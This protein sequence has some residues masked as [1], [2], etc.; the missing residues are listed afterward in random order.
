MAKPT[1]RDIVFRTLSRW[2][3][4]EDPPF[5]PERHHP[6]WAILSPRDR[7]FAYDLL[8]GILRW[9]G[10]LETVI[11][12][13]LNQRFE[14]LEMGLRVALWMGAYQLLFQGTADYAA[15]N[16]AVDLARKI[17]PRAA[18]LVNAVLRAITRLEPRRVAV[19]PSSDAAAP[20]TSRLGRHLIALDFETDL[21]LNTAIFSDPAKDLVG[22]L[23]GVRSHPA[24][25]VAHLLKIYPDQAAAV[26]LRNNQR[27]IITLRVDADQLDV[28]AAAG[29]AAHAEEPRFLVAAQ[30][31]SD[32]LEELV[33]SGKLS[34]QDPTAAQP[35]RRIAELVAQN[36]LPAPTRILDLCAGLGTKTV[37]LARTCPAARVIA[38]DL[39][40]EKLHRL[41]ARVQKLK[42]ANI[43]T[44]P[45][46]ET[47]NQKPDGRFDLI[48]LDVPCSNTGV[49]AKRVQSRWRWPTLDHA[50]LAAM[51]LKLLQQAAAI[52][53]PAGT[54]LYSTCS[55]DP[56]ENQERTQTFLAQNPAFSLV[57]QESRLPALTSAPAAPHDGGYFAI[58]R[59]SRA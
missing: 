8:T 15:V 13:R 27:P 28:P 54:I 33:D 16:T 36:N 52:L 21:R 45:L 37:Q 31:W 18:G 5:L 53:A 23:A 44:L 17:N 41:H 14:T 19:T 26:L 30:G 58:L 49:F 47:E 12:S 56:V 3:H 1:A 4:L 6:D 57:A 59:H 22:H 9:R 32:H 42:L 50:A 2:T 38:T 11:S 46:T 29:L 7:S 39:D 48:L 25:F 34:P 24:A 55:I 43:Q 35:I 40:N 10:T 20:I 51:Q